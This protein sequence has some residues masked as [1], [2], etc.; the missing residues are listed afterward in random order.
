M[1]SFNEY[2]YFD[3]LQLKHSFLIETGSYLV[4]LRYAEIKLIQQPSIIRRPIETINVY[5]DPLHLSA[6]I[7]TYRI[8]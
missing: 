7:S 2:W 3:S 8:P 5:S 1:N 4:S 6:R